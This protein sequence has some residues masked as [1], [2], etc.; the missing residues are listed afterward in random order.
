MTNH[1]GS[2]TACCRVF[3]IPELEKPAGKWCQ[4]CAIGNGCKVYDARPEVCVQFECLW[5]QSQKREP[6]EQMPA[7]LRPDKCKVVFSMSTNTHIM[8][9]I[10]MPGAPT[11]WE[12]PAVRAVIDKL[13]KHG[14][15][16]SVGAPGQTN[17]TFISRDGVKQIR[18]TEPDADGMMWSIPEQELTK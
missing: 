14:V 12:R 2:C 11:A 15:S 18:M 8:T 9:A 6:A 1:C 7:A 5:L 17:Q 3:A 10:T 13:V 4:H 16:V